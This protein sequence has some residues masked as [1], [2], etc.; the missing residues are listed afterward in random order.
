LN[1]IRTELEQDMPFVG[2]D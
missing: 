2:I 1:S